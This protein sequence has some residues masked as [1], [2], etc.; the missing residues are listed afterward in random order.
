MMGWQN[1]MACGLLAFLLECCSVHEVKVGGGG[2]L[3]MSCVG[4]GE[5]G[6]C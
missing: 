6:T 4:N 2:A 5:I 1:W 3:D